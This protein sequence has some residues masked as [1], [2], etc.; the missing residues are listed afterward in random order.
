MAK[1]RFEDEEKESLLSQAIKAAKR[2]EV[3]TSDDLAPSRPGPVKTTSSKIREA[4]GKDRESGTN[5]ALIDMLGRP[6]HREY[7]VAALNKEEKPKGGLL[8]FLA[9]AGMSG[10]S[11]LPANNTTVSANAMRAN[12]L[13]VQRDLRNKEKYDKQRQE[14][15]KKTAE[16]A[17]EHPVL[18]SAASVASAPFAMADMIEQM[19]EVS[20]L[21]HSLPHANQGV[22]EVT[23]NLRAGASSDMSK[24]G[25]F[26]YNTAMSGVDS[27]IA[28]M[29]G[30][31][32]LSLAGGAASSAMHDIK[33][34]GGDDQQ[35]IV[36]GIAA[37]VFEQLFESVS[38]G[39]LKA[40]REMPADSV[41]A[42]LKNAVKSVATNASEEAATELANITFD[43]LYMDELSSYELLIKDAVAQGMSEEEASKAAV[44]ALTGQIVESALS[45]AVMGA[46]MSTLASGGSALRQHT[47]DS[48]TGKQIKQNSQEYS[49]IQEGLNAEADSDVNRLAQQLADQVDKSKTAKVSNAQLGKLARTMAEA[50]AQAAA[51]ATQATAE[52]VR[53]KTATQEA[54]E[55]AQAQNPTVKVM[56]PTAQAYT[57]QGISPKAADAAADVMDRVLAG[58]TTLT[59]S[60]KRKLN[61]NSPA[62][63]AAFTQ[64]T[65]V[66]VANP[67]NRRA[68]LA[69]V[70][71]AISQAATQ[72]QAAAEARAAEQAN[73]AA[74]A[75][76]AAES[77][78]AAEVEQG[79]RTMA[80]AATEAQ[81][82]AGVPGE[83]SL[84][85]A[86][87]MAQDGPVAQAEA[88]T[89]EADPTE[90]P[91]AEAAAKLAALADQVEQRSAAA[92]NAGGGATVKLT[93][94]E[95]I[96]RAEF[97]QRFQAAH[98][99]ATPAEVSRAWSEAERTT[100]AGGAYLSAM[101]Q[102]QEGPAS[103]MPS[104]PGEV[105]SGGTA[106]APGKKRSPFLPKG[107]RSV[108]DQATAQTEAD[109]E[110]GPKAKGKRKGVI[111]SK[112][113]VKASTLDTRALPRENANDTMGTTR[114]FLKEDRENGG[115]RDE[116]RA[117]FLRR[118]TG[119]GLA[120]YEGDQ[121]SYGYRPVQGES[122]GENARQVQKEVKS[123]GID[124]DII[125]GPILWNYNG[126]T[127][128]REVPQAVTANGSHIFISNSASLSPRNMAG[129]EAFHLWKNSAGRDVY[130][131]T[132]EDNLIFTSPDFLNYQR[133]IAEAYLG[134]EADLTDDTQVKK[135]CEELFA[136]ISGDIHEGVND[137]FMRP[138]FR[139][140]DAVK[141]AWNSLV[142]ENVGE[143]RFSLKPS[144]DAATKAMAETE[145]REQS[146][147][148]EQ[149]WTV[150][151]TNAILR[152]SGSKLTV[153]LDYDGM[154]NNEPGFFDRD[155]KAIHLN[156]NILTTQRALIHTLGHEF[157]HTG[158]DSTRLKLVEDI[159]NTSYGTDEA[160]QAAL[161]Q[162]MEGTR[163]RYID[164]Y[165]QQKG[166]SPEDAVKM[167][168]DTFIREEVAADAMREVL[169]NTGGLYRMARENTGLL[170]NFRRKASDMLMQLSVKDEGGETL[171]QYKALRGIVD[172]LDE[173]IRVAGKEERG[174]EKAT[175]DMGEEAEAE[176]ETRA[177]K[178][179]AGEG[180]GTK[181]HDL[182]DRITPGMSE[183]ERYERLKDREITVPHYNA[184]KMSSIEEGGYEALENAGRDSAFK[185]LRKIGEQFGVFKDY[186]NTDM[187]LDFAFSRRGL[188]ESINKQGREFQNYA[189]MMSVFD[190]VVENAV[191]IE[192]HENRY[193]TRGDQVK[194]TFVFASAFQT[195]TGV[196]PVLLEVRTFTDDTKSGL[197]VA[198]SLQE[199]ERS[200]IVV[201]NTTDVS[202]GSPY[203]LPAS[204]LKLADI[205]ANV[206][207]EDGRMLK[208]LPDGFLNPEQRAA[209]QK[210]LREQKEYVD[211]KNAG[212]QRPTGKRHS[213]TYLPWDEQIDSLR[214][215][216]LN[217]VL[218]GNGNFNSVMYVRR[219]A[220]ALLQEVGLSDLPLITTQRH[221]RDM[222]TPRYDQNGKVINGKF[223]DLSEAQMKN[224]PNM[225]ANPVAIFR[226]DP[227]GKSAGGLNIL[228]SEVD[229]QGYPIFVTINPDRSSFTY[230]GA[231]GPAHFVNAF[232]RANYKEFFDQCFNNGSVLYVN[233]KEVQTQ[234][235]VSASIRRHMGA[236]GLDFDT[237][238]AEKDPTVKPGERRYSVQPGEVN[239][240]TGYEKGSIPDSLVRILK[241]DE[242]LGRQV[243]QKIADDL[244]GMEKQAEQE[245]RK[246]ATSATFA[247]KGKLT[248]TAVARNR[249]AIQALLDKYGE[250]PQTSAAQQP[251]H[252]PKQIDD[253]TKVRGFMQT[254]AAVSEA[255]EAVLDEFER[256]IVEG[257]AGATYVPIKDA[258][259]LAKVQAELK[260]KDFHTVMSEWE[261]LVDN[262]RKALSK[263]DIAKGEQ[264]LIE[265]MR[266]KDVAS[267]MRLTA[268]LSAAATQAGQVVQ[269]MTLLKKMSPTGKLYYVQRAVDRLNGQSIGKHP[270]ITI[271][272]QLAKNLLEAK[273][274]EEI[275][276]AMDA[277]IQDIADQVPVTWEDKWNAWRY[278]SMLGNPRTH[279][280][281]LMGNA[282]FLPVRLVK[283]TVGTMLERVVLPKDQR[284]KSL[285]F[286][287]ALWNFAKQD[288]EEMRDVLSGGG[289]QNPSDMIRDKQRVFKLGALNWLQKKN[290]D[291]LDAEDWMFLRGSYQRSLASFLSA[292]G[293]TVDQVSGPDSTPEGRAVLDQARTWAIR[294]AQRA[295]YRDLSALA[296][297]LN[298]AK[299]RSPRYVRPFLEGVVPFTKT[300]I[301]VVKRGIEYSPYG[302]AEGLV[303]MATSVRKGDMTAA[304]A[305]DKFC[306]GMTGTMIMTLGYF[307]TKSGWLIGDHDK[308]EEDEF[309]ELQG[310][311]AYSLRFGDTSY[312]I[313]WAAP[314]ALPLFV[315]AEMYNVFHDL[316]EAEEVGWMQA[317]SVAADSMTSILE[318]ILNLSMLDGL[319][320]TLSANRYGEEDDALYNIAST[321]LTSY[322]TQGVPTILGQ[323][324]RTMD[325][326]RRAAFIPKG[327]GKVEG[328]A[329]YT[330]QN[331]VLGK[332]PGA[333]KKRMPYIDAWGR[334][335]TEGSTA[336]RALEN[337][338]SPGYIN[339]VKTTPVE[340]ELERLAGATKNNAV[341]PNRAE[342]YFALG[343]GTVHN[344]TQ[345][346]YQAHL[347]ERGQRSYKLVGDIINDGLYQELDDK[348]RAVAVSYAYE[349]AAD[350]AKIHTDPKYGSAS[351]WVSELEQAEKRGV[352][353]AEYLMLK[354][355]AKVTG[356]NLT[357][358]AL[359]SK[360]LSDV[361]VANIVAME[362]N[363]P[364]SFADPYRKGYEY[365]MTDKQ[366]RKFEEVY[367]RIL[368]EEYTRLT[369][370]KA[371]QKATASGRY[372]MLTDVK[373]DVGEATRKEISDWLYHQGI[374]STPKK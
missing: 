173:A 301:N 336:I 300:P 13:L 19:T 28:S 15:A 236:H 218:R 61:L 77:E 169:L 134:G 255:N 366:I 205:F 175:A 159:L 36:G 275:K 279:V 312:T 238:I 186:H 244:A 360:S 79:A 206:K 350:L 368:T 95:S 273:T 131:E 353:P 144:T 57:D 51:Q 222:M 156:G 364:D 318:P 252:F 359:G 288:A 136:Y 160:G 354:A 50:Q 82:G 56:S 135:L 176:G 53:P 85:L 81:E 151:R 355:E 232:G 243:L 194:E 341:F 320:K 7:P 308:D 296:R 199:I 117:A 93:N 196:I 33:A 272:E 164:F 107:R 370:D 363:T 165:T 182:T 347:L 149:E 10:D 237:I 103:G 161:A 324:A 83:Q 48:S 337:F 299:R 113:E 249:K 14:Q 221:A 264:L 225:I 5:D 271:N 344:M 365:R 328:T 4:A 163:R 293:Y 191:G 330:F 100:K 69:D 9:M 58:D 29:T 179:A 60:Q 104:A 124:A 145:T 372:D 303:N 171:E 138:M 200:R 210:T 111:P 31:G 30:T 157:V 349:Y 298:N 362:Y 102:T 21:G 174:Q 67:S 20:A 62:Y 224:L 185:I 68:W 207:A 72:A 12:P 306:A 44:K 260:R 22:S 241:G 209:K 120:V 290:S 90:A 80:E 235:P 187:E 59:E 346:E 213:V 257:D 242:V 109:G 192:A 274:S 295:T 42:M 167:C 266:N 214:A 233:K 285:T 183:E 17:E 228:T 63:R 152:K 327:A 47:A 78:V 92:V 172:R 193:K 65:G 247:P 223:H 276:T 38:L 18:A 250:M 195:D 287:K 282:V 37:G 128:A 181:R 8:D 211:R 286:S 110:T 137:E 99:E 339:T 39:Q 154:D 269:A 310:E 75:R 239:P 342:K 190:D 76:A 94:G 340:E 153:E 369:E 259:V 146:R 323:I 122:A 307:L 219:E 334:I 345:E 139:D 1:T 371:F 89:V 331:S 197:Y 348:T 351:K 140:F 115:A 40:L 130:I 26:F 184:E 34:R 302:L 55:Q 141:A 358:V 188:Q 112:A 180:S 316:S 227:K 46:G 71:T 49:L 292:R 106:Q 314:T 142:R 212:R 283:D 240:D 70:D 126:I 148:R 105:A 108:V 147:R 66:E 87:T 84:S 326:T 158:S 35:A 118:A 313:D 123:L 143:T 202:D 297:A 373:R 246:T 263:E 203:T 129:H 74:E 343:D 258:A 11:T 333:S 265:A 317:F 16:W 127:S 86:R 204:K 52:A 230:D 352:D 162:D 150:R 45:G 32:A 27:Y 315:G 281:N 231:V 54:V 356:E 321:A 132:V 97:A 322:V 41:K 189:K 177:E 329:L 43:T 133:A 280:R 248:E 278:L 216:T 229:S 96:G 261:G 201:Y 2:G 305:L 73:A 253:D 319:N 234:T 166:L 374:D 251:V 178:T 357:T 304:E 217:Q 277:L 220:P 294:E 332:L 335:D 119:E 125:D 284:T 98:P 367:L 361:D 101:L 23:Q 168:D 289:K 270:E 6:K 155:T 208:Y 245:K 338:I 309:D 88:S 91:L 325:D 262:G 215:G 121:I 311:Q 226:S 170:R 114:Y 291:L 256:A 268:D 25:K 254:A 24:V 3:I 64:L 116:T 267:A 198:V